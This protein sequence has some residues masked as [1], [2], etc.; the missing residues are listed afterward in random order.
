MTFPRK[1]LIAP[2]LLFLV[3]IGCQKTPPDMVRVPAG[4][5]LMGTDEVDTE[6]EA[7]EFGLPHPWYE[8]EHPLQKIYLDTYFIDKYEVTYSQ[9]SQFVRATGH[10][11]PEDWLNGTY[12]PEKAD[13]PVVYVNWYDA[14]DYCY[15]KGKR[16]PTEAEWEKAARGPDGLKYPWGNGFNPDLAHV[17]KEAVM[18]SAPVAV[19]RYEAGKSPYGVYDLIGNVW[20]WTDSW[21]EPY[22]GNTARNEN[23]GR[24]LRVTRG[25]SF[26]SVGHFPAEA[27]QRAVSIIA[28]ASFRSY[29]FP[30]SRLAD[31]G[32]RC[33]RS[34]R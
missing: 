19:G 25:L 18:V 16:L 12:P 32:F 11:P 5:F 34:V 6:G 2:L 17:A 1:S 10:H 28:R 7:M 29:D 8:D 30:T 15:W 21:Y 24:N 4:D 20:E 27:Y 13:F 3:M 22:P 26:M 14:N 33:A 31:L 23:F 9:Y